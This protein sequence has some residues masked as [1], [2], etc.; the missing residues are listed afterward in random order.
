MGTGTDS[1]AYISLLSFLPGTP[2]E[3]LVT[4]HAIPAVLLLR[5]AVIQPGTTALGLAPTI[6]ELV[7]WTAL[8]S[9]PYGEGLGKILRGSVS[10]RGGSDG[11]YG[12]QLPK[13]IEEPSCESTMTCN[14]ADQVAAECV[15][16][17]YSHLWSG[18][19]LFHAPSSV[20]ALL[21]TNPAG[22]HSRA[23]G[24]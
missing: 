13:H 11:S 3:I 14:A 10:R 2:I 23:K 6:A 9:I 5:S 20:Q 17:T 8:I 1:Q 15:A 22:R 21:H 19:L 4:I 12:K 16:L 24:G 7:F 18:D